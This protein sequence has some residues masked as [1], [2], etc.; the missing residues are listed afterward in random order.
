MYKCM[1]NPPSFLAT[2]IIKP[3]TKTSKL[4]DWTPLRDAP[5]QICRHHG[6]GINPHLLCTCG[7][8]NCTETQRGSKLKNH[9]MVQGGTPPVVFVGLQ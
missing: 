2:G 6:G 5:I 3:T 9:Q 7:H 1:V 4:D 8:R